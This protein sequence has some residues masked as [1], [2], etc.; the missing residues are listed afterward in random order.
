MADLDNIQNLGGSFDPFAD[1]AKE[2]AA[3]APKD[4]VHI[5]VQQRN[6]RKCLTTVQGINPKID[7]KKVIKAFKKE[8]ACNG[9]VIEDEEFGKVIQL[10]GDHR[11]D[12]KDFLITMKVCQEE[13]IIVHGF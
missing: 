9:T 5:R 3:S 4:I 8:F 6:G 13:Q 10:Q 11:A 1:A 7:L 12:V 2:E